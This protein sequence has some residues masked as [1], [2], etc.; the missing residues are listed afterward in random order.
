MSKD[1]QE[2]QANGSSEQATTEKQNTQAEKKT[3]SL[4]TVDQYLRRA[5]N[6][7]EAI[8]GLIRSMYKTEIMTFEAWEEKITALLKKKTW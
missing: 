1:K 6:Y 5:E 8:A 2:Q 3:Q 7:D 4:L